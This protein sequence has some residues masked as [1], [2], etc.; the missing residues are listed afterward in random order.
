MKASDFEYDGQLLSDF[1]FM[2]CNFGSTDTVTIADSQLTFNTV[3]T[4][5][6]K[7]WVLTDSKYET[8][9]ECTFQICKIPFTKKQKDMEISIYEVR[10]MK[11]WLERNEFLKFK[12]IDEDDEH[13]FE[14]LYFEGT[15]NLSQIE[16][17]SKI[18]GLE[19][20]LTTNRPYAV[21][22]DVTIEYEWSDV[23]FSNWEED[24][25][26]CAEFYFNDIS[27]EIGYIYPKMTITFLRSGD[28]YIWDREGRCMIFKN[29]VADEV[30][31][32]DYPI[33][34]TSLKTHDIADDFNYVFYRISNDYNDRKNLFE[35]DRPCKIEMTYN[36]VVKVGI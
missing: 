16:V 3:S 20:T 31:T 25:A 18:L 26:Y 34:K 36:P 29:C 33:I 19:L 8:C 10:D 21:H 9:L 22:E 5:K 35:T 30:I 15:F 28:L 2:I 4:N 17:G 14:E 11:R 12:P 23:D 27:D 6:G 24:S 1:G 13:C 7:K 32:V